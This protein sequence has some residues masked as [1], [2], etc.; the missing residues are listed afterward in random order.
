MLEL[1]SS[2]MLFFQVLASYTILFFGIFSDKYLR[3]KFLRCPIM[4]EVF[5]ETQ[6][7]LKHLF[8]T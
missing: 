7:Y 2:T 1:T 8:M 4:G 5:L 3:Q 6:P